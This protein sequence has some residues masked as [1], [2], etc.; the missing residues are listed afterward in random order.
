LLTPSYPQL[1]K[2]WNFKLTPDLQASIDAFT[3]WYGTQHR[4]RQLSWRHQLATVTLSGR[5]ASGKYEIGVSLFQA[6][7]MMQFNEEDSLTYEEVS[8][9]TGIGEWLDMFDLHERR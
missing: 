8:E 5:F 4:N 6:V 2:G 7:V 9:R 3:S 1:K